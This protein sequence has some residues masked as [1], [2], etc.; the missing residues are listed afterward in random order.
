MNTIAKFY[1][2]KKILITGATGFKG[3]WLCAWLLSLGSKIKGIGHN[4]NS[5]QKLFHSLGLTKKVNLTLFDI[6]DKKK[7]DNVIKKFKPGII[8][9]LAA[10]PLVSES[11]KNPY[12]TFDINF[13]GTLNIIDISM[14]YKFIKSIISVTSDKCYENLNKIKQYSEKDRLGGID[15]YSASKASAELL[16]RSYRKSFFH[17]TGISS[18]RA[19]NVIG[20]GDW[21][22]NRLIPDCIRYINK[23]L[24]IR[25]RN[26]NYNRPWQFVLEP[27]KGYLILAK[28]Q[29]EKP[30]KFSSSWNF[31]PKS[32]NFKSVKDVVDLIIKFWGKGSVTKANNKFHEHH[33][34]QLNCNKAK[35][36]LNWKPVYNVN[37]SIKKTIEWYYK[38]TNDKINP[39][40]ITNDQINKYMK[41]S[42][43]I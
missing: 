27:L 16:I 18:V 30:K 8:F 25:L 33:H 11:Y 7:L 39:K 22:K 29:Y 40:I 24:K 37:Q 14:K 21:S 2:N 41:D 42:K 38:V 3:A 35:Q 19:G 31:G 10:Q 26:P 5:N 4:P 17:R 6:R 28:K 1:R 13:R 20:G 9:H 43:W 15:P 32:N 36:I 34:L 12:Q 23:N